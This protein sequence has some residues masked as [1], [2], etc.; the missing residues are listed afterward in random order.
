MV[1]MWL[2]KKP[3]YEDPAFASCVDHST[4]AVLRTDIAIDVQI[5]RNKTIDFVFDRHFLKNNLPEIFFFQLFFFSDS[6]AMRTQ[7][8]SLQILASIRFQLGN[9]KV[10]TYPDQ[11]MALQRTFFS[12]VLSKSANRRRFPHLSCSGFDSLSSLYCVEFILP[13]RLYKAVIS[14]FV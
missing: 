10:G 12:V 3:F 8:I 9:I 1:C 13:N 14:C 11:I 6:I 2:L 7:P 4:P 5:N